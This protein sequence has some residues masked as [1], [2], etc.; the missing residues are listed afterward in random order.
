[1]ASV[2]KAQLSLGV[3]RQTIMSWLDSGKFP[4]AEK[5]G[6]G[7]G[8]WDIPENDIEAVRLERI[9]YHRREIENLE[10]SRERYSGIQ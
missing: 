3:S 4:N 7:R 5:R 8:E 6:P 9:E 2:L 1:M 10:A